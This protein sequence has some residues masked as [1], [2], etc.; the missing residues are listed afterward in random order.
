MRGELKWGAH[1]WVVALLAAA[2]AATAWWAWR[3]NATINGI[4]AAMSAQDAS[5]SR[6]QA[7][8]TRLKVLVSTLGELKAQAAV[9]LAPT[10]EA[11]GAT[12]GA[13][14]RTVD[15]LPYIQKDPLY[16]DLHRRRM[17]QQVRR[18][19]GDLKFLGL[20][21]DQEARLTLLLSNKMSAYQDG[22]DAALAQG[23]ADGTPEMGRAINQTSK[24]AD[25]EI[26]ALV[27][28][29]GF[30]DLNTRASLVT[31]RNSINMALSP[32]FLTGGQAL[33]LDQM[34][35][36]AD[37]QYQFKGTP[38]ELDQAMRD[39]ASQVL[40]PDQLEIFLQNRTLDQ[41]SR[42]LQQRATDA[43]TKETGTTSF[44]WGNW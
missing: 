14:E 1:A 6:D 7:E 24:S 15:L 40:T 36:L 3:E 32:Y 18:R 25:D 31:A 10:K 28:D 33:S 11:A 43:A 38:S 16:A 4:R 44:R 23:I 39:R 17:L 42:D 2:L 35:A 9:P 34:N 26:K 19:Y 5:R 29:S 13:T 8:I 30:Q 27:G 12:S 22:H 37:A 20:P 41:E 21:P